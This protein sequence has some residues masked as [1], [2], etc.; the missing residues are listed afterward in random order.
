MSVLQC[1]RCE[2]TGFLNLDQVDEE[3]LA[4]FEET[5]DPQ[6]ILDWIADRDHRMEEAGGCSCHVCPPCYYCVELVHDVSVCD[7]CGNGEPWGWYF[8][9]GLHD[10]NNP[11]DPKGCR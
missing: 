10:W 5:S 3:T 7:C 8:L 9:P 4:H 11:D 6:V 2:G 1:T